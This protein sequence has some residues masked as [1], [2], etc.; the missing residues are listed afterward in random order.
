MG[1]IGLEKRPLYCDHFRIGN[2]RY[3][4]PIASFGEGWGRKSIPYLLHRS[5]NGNFLSHLRLEARHFSHARAASPPMAAAASIE[6][7]GGGP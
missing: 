3:R 2:I 5:Q 7:Y 6:L 1:I 4:D